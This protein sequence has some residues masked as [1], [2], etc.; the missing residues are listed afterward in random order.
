ML[1]ELTKQFKDLA[2]EVY[3]LAPNVELEEEA[4]IPKVK[5]KQKKQF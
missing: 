2:N 5:G 3:P 4:K 1:Y